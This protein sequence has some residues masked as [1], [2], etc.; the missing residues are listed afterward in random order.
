MCEKCVE[1]DKKIYHYK[2]V[3]GQMSDGRTLEGINELI[4]QHEAKK[5]SLHPEKE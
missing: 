5:R 3:A 4:E 2:W 1:I